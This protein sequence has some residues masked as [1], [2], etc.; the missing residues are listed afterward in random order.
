MASRY[1]EVIHWFIIGFLFGAITLG[2]SGLFIGPLI[3]GIAYVLL[4]GLPG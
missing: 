1:T 4:P 2:L 3:V